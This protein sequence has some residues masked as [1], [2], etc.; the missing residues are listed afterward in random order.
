MAVADVTIASEGSGTLRPGQSALLEDSGRKSTVIIYLEPN[1]SLSIA[2]RGPRAPSPINLLPQQLSC[3]PSLALASSPVL[4]YAAIFSFLLLCLH[5]LCLILSTPWCQICLE[6]C[7]P[8]AQ[9]GGEGICMN[10]VEIIALL[11]EKRCAESSRDQRGPQGPA[12]SPALHPALLPSPS[13]RSNLRHFLWVLV[14]F[15]C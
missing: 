4:S 3:C 8:P 5:L 1:S 13:Q 2:P 7:V 10:V 9:Q 12:G 14:R 6:V 15:P 11:R